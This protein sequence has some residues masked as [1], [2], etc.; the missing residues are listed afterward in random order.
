MDGS[1]KYGPETGSASRNDAESGDEAPLQVTI[2]EVCSAKPRRR[3]P[4]EHAFRER[5]VKV[6]SEVRQ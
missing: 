1:R 4:C 5:G 6:E 3:G 2:G